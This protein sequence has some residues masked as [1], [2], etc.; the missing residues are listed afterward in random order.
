MRKLALALAALAAAPTVYAADVAEVKAGGATIT[1]TDEAGPCVKTA[2][3]A[4]FTGPSEPVP[5]PGCWIGWVD[6]SG[7]PFVI[8]SFLDGERA[9]IPAQAL[10]SLLRPA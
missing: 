9:N 6:E 1:L 7:Q 2:R 5:V 4:R 8:V 10:R 3:L